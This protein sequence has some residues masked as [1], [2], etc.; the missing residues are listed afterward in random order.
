MLRHVC[1][2]RRSI[3]AGCSSS[4]GRCLLW[5]GCKQHVNGG[6]LFECHALHADARL[7][8]CAGYEL[9]QQ[10]EQRRAFS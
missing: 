7:R 5:D 4:C 6:Q 9:L 2:C 1:S 10:A 8:L 3:V